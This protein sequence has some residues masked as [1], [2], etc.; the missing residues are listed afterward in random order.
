MD[1]FGYLKR[2]RRDQAEVEARCAR[3]RSQAEDRRLV[4]NDVKGYKRGSDAATSSCERCEDR[5]RVTLPKGLS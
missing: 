5:L 2:G 3:S 1:T 4:F